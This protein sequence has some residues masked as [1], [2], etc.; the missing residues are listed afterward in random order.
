[1]SGFGSEFGGATGLHTPLEPG[2]HAL[3]SLQAISSHLTRL[4]RA[5]VATHNMQQRPPVGGLCHQQGLLA[6]AP[7]RHFAGA[8]A[9]PAA[10]PRPLGRSGVAAAAATTMRPL[11]NLPSPGGFASLR[12]L[13]IDMDQDMSDLELRDVKVRRQALP[14]A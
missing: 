7:A 6:P 3:S 2:K 5:R 14:V 11:A 12:D 13:S 4:W 8:A 9:T 1:M 10:A